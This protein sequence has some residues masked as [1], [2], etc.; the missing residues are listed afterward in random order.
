M[1]SASYTASGANQQLEKQQF[2][3]QVTSGNFVN[4]ELRQSKSRTSE[5]KPESVLSLKYDSF[6]KI[7][8]SCWCV[9]LSATGFRVCSSKFDSAVTGDC[10]AE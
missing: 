5:A 2:T 10:G 6:T 4:E 9:R 3:L 1:E 8:D 7:S